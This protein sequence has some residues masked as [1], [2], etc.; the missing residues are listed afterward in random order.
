M[1]NVPLP[2]FVDVCN[3]L[4]VD[5][6]GDHSHR[7]GADGVGTITVTVLIW[8]RGGFASARCSSHKIDQLPLLER[9]VL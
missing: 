7:I 4:A 1:A 6:A 3:A 5:D 2:F 9:C 8:P